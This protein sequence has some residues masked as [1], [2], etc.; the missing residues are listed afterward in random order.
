MKLINNILKNVKDDMW[1]IQ[2]I[3]FNL[4][5]ENIKFKYYKTIYQNILNV[6]RFP[7]DYKSF[8]NNSIY[9]SYHIFKFIKN[10]NKIKSCSKMHTVDWWG[11][12][13]NKLS[14]KIT[15][16]FFFVEINKK[17]LIKHYKNIFV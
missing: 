13:Q 8:K 4:N 14:N 9:E 16:M 12:I 6:L 3:I 7:F 17:I 2:K 1:R 5:Y 10:N 15:L 11:E